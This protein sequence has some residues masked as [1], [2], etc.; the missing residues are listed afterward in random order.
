MGKV[1][2]SATYETLDQ[3]IIESMQ[4]NPAINPAFIE[5][6][7]YWRRSLGVPSE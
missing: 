7:N 3:F 2:A 5:K 6:I 4:F 1:A